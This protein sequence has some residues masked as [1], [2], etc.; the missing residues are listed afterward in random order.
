MCAWPLSRAQTNGFLA[1]I[2]SVWIYNPTTGAS[3]RKRSLI[4]TLK[5]SCLNFSVWKLH[6]SVVFHPCF[7]AGFLS[8]LSG[9][10]VALQDR[11]YLMDSLQAR[12]L[13]HI[14]REETFLRSTHLARRR[15]F[16]LDALEM[17]S[18]QRDIQHVSL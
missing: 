13:C 8:I 11:K 4:V 2:Y 14:L 17:L 10:W 16:D 12:V 1:K 5:T 7:P 18:Y 9:R 15:G 6:K 3:F